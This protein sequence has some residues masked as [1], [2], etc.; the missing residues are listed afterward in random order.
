[1]NYIHKKPLPG[2]VDTDSKQI[3]LRDYHTD[4]RRKLKIV[5]IK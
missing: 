2:V 4:M 1:M 5:V 3:D